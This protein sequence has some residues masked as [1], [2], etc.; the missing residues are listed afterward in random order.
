[1]PSKLTTIL[2]VGGIP[3]VTA[4]QGSGLYAVVKKYNIGLIVEAENQV[5]LNE[6]I[7]KAVT[8]D[9]SHLNKNA[10][11]YAENYLSIENIMKSF[12]RGR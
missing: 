11:A 7:L 12:T 4:N 6:G 3:L 8:E 10:R 2:A 1:M 5:A 9:F